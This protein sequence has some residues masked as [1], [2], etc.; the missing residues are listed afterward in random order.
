MDVPSTEEFLSSDD[1]QILRSVLE[2]EENDGEFEGDSVWI[3]QFV[4]AK[5][6]IHEHMLINV[7]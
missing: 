3:D 4:V 2:L 6:F 7:Q 1:Q 5:H